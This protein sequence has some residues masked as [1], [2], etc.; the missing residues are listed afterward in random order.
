MANRMFKPL[1]GHFNSG[2]A[3]ID[4]YVDI[5]ADASVSSSAVDGATVTK[6]GTGQY[7]VTLADTYNELLACN[8]TVQA[9]TAVDLVPQVVS[10]DVSSA[11]TIVFKLLAAA[12][13][14]D[15]SAVC[16]VYVS[17]KLKNSSVSI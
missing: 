14:T 10:Q 6:T 3:L 15:P 9:A 1:H 12:T 5:A 4:G 13:A 2:V 11:K 7:T 8:L 17:L 16:R